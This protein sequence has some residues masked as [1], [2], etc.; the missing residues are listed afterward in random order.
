MIAKTMKGVSHGQE[1]REKERQITARTEGGGLETSQH[2]D[3][4]REE[5]PEQR[6]QLQQ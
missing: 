3:T 6:Q 1:R 4:M 5:E 2:T